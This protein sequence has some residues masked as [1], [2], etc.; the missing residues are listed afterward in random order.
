MGKY[1]LNEVAEKQAELLEKLKDLP[2]N[3]TSHAI[4]DLLGIQIKMAHILADLQEKI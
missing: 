4:L 1:T 3:D 2:A